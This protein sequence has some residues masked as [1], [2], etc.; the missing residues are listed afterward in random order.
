ME[1]CGVDGTAALSCTNAIVP[2]GAAI[3]I[4]AAADFVG[5]LMEVAVSVTFAGLGAALGAV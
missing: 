1:D 2:A 5:S 4:A 3:V